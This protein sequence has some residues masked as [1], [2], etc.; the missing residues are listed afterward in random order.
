[1]LSEQ[2]LVLNK[3]EMRI[4]PDPGTASTGYGV[5]MRLLPLFAYDSLAQR[6]LLPISL[7]H[8]DSKNTAR[9]KLSNYDTVARGSQQKGALF[10]PEELLLTT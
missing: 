2:A 5:L 4:S 9:L 6:P 10:C 8:R 7:Q 1:V 3:P